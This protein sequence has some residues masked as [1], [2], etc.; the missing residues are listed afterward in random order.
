MQMMVHEIDRLSELLRKLLYFSR[1]IR[2]ELMRPLKADDIIRHT[3]QFANPHLAEKRVELRLELAALKEQ[4]LGDPD[5]LH[6][7]FLNIL[8]NS[9]Q[10][11]DEGGSI[12]IATRTDAKT[13]Y[14]VIDLEDSGPGVPLELRDKVLTPFYTTRPRGSGLGLAIAYEIIRAH[15]GTLEF[16]DAEHLSGAHCRIR[17]PPNAKTRIRHA[18]ED[19]SVKKRGARLK[20]RIDSQ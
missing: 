4:I 5:A 20:G 17:L 14:L 1:P 15:G 9:I 13:G 10:M 16:A 6:Q 11:V 2:P 19:A 12:V 7:V 8:N 3:V 18:A